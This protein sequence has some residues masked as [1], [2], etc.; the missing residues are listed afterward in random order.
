MTDDE[1]RRLFDEAVPDLPAPT[2]R[3]SAVAARVR[4]TRRRAAA[5]SAVAAVVAIALA[6]G[7]PAVLTAPHAGTPDP[8]AATPAPT[9]SPSPDPTGPPPSS[10]PLDAAGCPAAVPPARWGDNGPGPLVRTGAVQVT[11]CERQSVG[12]TPG[13]GPLAGP[14]RTLTVG[15]DQ[16]TD[17]L[18]RLVD[19][20]TLQ[21]Q[22]RAEAVQRGL[23]PNLVAG[24]NVCLAI[25][26]GTSFSLVL[27]YPDG[28]YTVVWLNR[29][30]GTATADGKTRY[31]TPGDAVRTADG[32]PGPQQTIDLFLRLYPG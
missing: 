14:P 5:G 16:I 29:A 25:G 21:A 23:D 13:L 20:A 12:T 17:Q 24:P 32:S 22:R 2:D 3:L 10:P 31:G 19:A 28:T 7:V 8:L 18:N 27:R 4:R 26:Y 11:L 6:I 1:L 9:G 15:V 30:C